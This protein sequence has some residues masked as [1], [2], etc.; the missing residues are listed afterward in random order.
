LIENL[1]MFSRVTTKALPF[2]AVDLAAVARDVLSD[3]ESRIAETAGR[4]ELAELPSMFADAGQMHQLFQNLLVNALKFHRAGVPPVVHVSSRA[5]PGGDRF[6]LRVQDNGL[7]FE[8]QYAERIFGMFQRLHGR[9]EFEGTGIGLA[10]CR[11]IVE[12]HDGT[13][14]ASGVLGD[15]AVF[16]VTLPYRQPEEIV[17]P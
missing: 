3:L 17:L 1:L 7:G 2:V 8:Q 15:G 16:S 12:R 9:S 11:K 6:E 5:L 14:V 13:I 4:V 10:I